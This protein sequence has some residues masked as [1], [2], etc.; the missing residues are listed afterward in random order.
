M[1]SSFEREPRE[2]FL[3][4]ACRFVIVLAAVVAI[5]AGLLAIYIGLIQL[6]WF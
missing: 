4:K 2:T 3:G 5:P 6:G 1:M